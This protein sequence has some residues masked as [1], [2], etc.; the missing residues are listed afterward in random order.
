MYF[1]TALHSAVQ[2]DHT[3]FVSLLLLYGADLDIKDA[4][5]KTALELT[6]AQNHYKC[7]KLLREEMEAIK[8]KEMDWK[9]CK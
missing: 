7:G 6:V 2:G 1:Q 4:N 9:Y 3:K 8:I 5:G